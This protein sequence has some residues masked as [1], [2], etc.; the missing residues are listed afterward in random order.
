MIEIYKIIV[1]DRCARQVF[2]FCLMARRLY[3]E[4]G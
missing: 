1:S 4:F 3:E 2:K